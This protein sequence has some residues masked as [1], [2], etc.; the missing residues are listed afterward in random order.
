MPAQPLVS[1]IIP[2]YNR[3]NVISKTIDNVFG[4]TYKN[5]ELIVVDD[6]STDDTSAILRKYA[7]RIRVVTQNN[8]GAA[9][10]RNRGVEVSRGDI[11]AFQDSDDLW[12][13]TKL[14]R[15]VRI[16]ERVGESVPC[17]LCNVLMKNRYGD[18]KDYHSFDL[19][20]LH[21]AYEEGLW[22]NVTEVLA[23]RFVLFNQAVAIRRKTIEKLGGFDTSFNYIDDYDL[24]LRLSLEGP[25]AY[26]SDP[27]TIWAGGTPD[28]LA[29]KATDDAI[30]LKDCELRIFERALAAAQEQRDIRV[31]RQLKRRIA[32]FRRALS[33]IRIGQSGSSFARMVA[34]TQEFLDCKYY[35]IFTRSPWFP[36]MKVVA[37]EQFESG[38]QGFDPR[39]RVR[40]NTP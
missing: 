25:W 8:A 3:A 1:V 34:R 24:P 6:G 38:L 32:K 22:L 28:S 18:G 9:A 19:S 4:Q 30:L 10:A 5:M 14:E 23:T 31:E 26:I 37:I 20:L 40:Q 35:A 29:K 11:I 15:Q 7:D 17:C 13:A 2:T 39:L 12:M 16:L 21:P 33:A 36:E 27:L